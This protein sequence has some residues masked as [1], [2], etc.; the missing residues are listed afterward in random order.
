MMREELLSEVAAIVEKT[1]EGGKPVRAAW[2]AKTIVDDHG[3]EDIEWLQRCSLE[4]VRNAVRKVLRRYH[5]DEEGETDPQL[6][7]P[8]YQRVQ[9]AYLVRRRGQQVVVPIEK[10]S[11]AEIRLKITELRRMADGCLEHGEELERYLVKRFGDQVEE[12]GA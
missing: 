6:T 3:T 7:L 9:K 1:I 10:L 8:G 2:V 5:P 11:A 4:L 12:A